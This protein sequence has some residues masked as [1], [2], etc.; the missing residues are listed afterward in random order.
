STGILGLVGFGMRR[1]KTSPSGEKPGRL[2][3]LAY[4]FTFVFWSRPPPCALLAFQKSTWRKIYMRFL[5]NRAMMVALVLGAAIIAP[6]TV[7]AEYKNLISATAPDET[8][9]GAI[10]S[11]SQPGSGTGIFPSFVQIGGNNNT[12][13]GYNTTVNNVLD[14][15]SSDQHN[16]E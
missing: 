14:N 7:M 10:F 8:I 9:N 11:N 2:C 12:T 6:Q 5:T 13:S 4:R 3:R 1:K 16:H 15:G